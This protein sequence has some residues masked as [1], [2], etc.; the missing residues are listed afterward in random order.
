MK[1]TNNLIRKYLMKQQIHHTTQLIGIKDQNITLNK[2][3]QYDT[4]IEVSATLDCNP[5][6]CKHCKGKQIKYDF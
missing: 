5:P 4:H 6:K 3:I 1:S 2:T